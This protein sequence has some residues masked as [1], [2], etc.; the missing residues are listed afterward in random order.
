MEKYL[1][2]AVSIELVNNFLF[3]AV[4]Q[5]VIVFVKL[6]YAF[7]NYSKNPYG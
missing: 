6:K 4:M 1:P 7:T 2:G 5:S 3:D